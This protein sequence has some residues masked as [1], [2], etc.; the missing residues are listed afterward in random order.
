M[1]FLSEVTNKEEIFKALL[2]FIDVFPHLTEKVCNLE[3]Y[4]YKLEQYANVYY[5]SINDKIFGL[6]VLYTN[7][8]EA[9]ESYISLIGVKQEFRHKG[10][11]TYLLQEA[12]KMS[13]CKKMKSIRLEVDNDNE[14]A[15][16][17]YKRNGFYVCGKASESSKYMMKKLAEERNS[18]RS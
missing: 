10:F 15:I 16:D 11:G 6:L 5:G 9:L 17:F 14:E 1:K 13:E 12:Q 7:N 2:L 18:D 3:D 8:G 4:A